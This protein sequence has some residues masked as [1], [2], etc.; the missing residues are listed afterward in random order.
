MLTKRKNYKPKEHE[1]EQ[2]KDPI[3][4]DYELH[5]KVANLFTEREEV[6]TAVVNQKVAELNEKILD[7]DTSI[8]QIDV[9]RKARLEIL[10]ILDMLSRYA[11]SYERRK[12][13]L[14]E[15]KNNNNNAGE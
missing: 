5:G 12:E 8:E 10:D 2:F 6:I 15:N 3:I 1:L 13:E 7:M 14:E 4:N 9:L 11:I